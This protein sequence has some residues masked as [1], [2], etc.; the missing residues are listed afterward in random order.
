MDDTP[1]PTGTTSSAAGPSPGDVGSFA[2]GGAVK[3]KSCNS[4]TRKSKARGPRPGT[5]RQTYDTFVQG[6]YAPFVRVVHRMTKAVSLVPSS[7]LAVPAPEGGPAQEP[8]QPVQMMTVWR[9]DVPSIIGSTVPG[10]ASAEGSGP[11]PQQE[12]MLM[13]VESSDGAVRELNSILAE[14]LASEEKRVAE[15]DKSRK[16]WAD[17][18]QYTGPTPHVLSA[19]D[20]DE[21]VG[22]FIDVTSPTAVT[23]SKSRY[24]ALYNI[25]YLYSDDELPSANTGATAA[26]VDEAAAIGG[27]GGAGDG[28][29]LESSPGKVDGPVEKSA[30]VATAGTA[31]L[32]SGVAQI[33]SPATE[34]PVSFADAVTPVRSNSTKAELIDDGDARQQRGTKPAHLPSS[35]A[36]STEKVVGARVYVDG[37]K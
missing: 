37:E 5:L 15:G 28:V 20:S 16:E 30:E 35:R 34:I 25:R 4:S 14:Y 26:A 23:G 6:R 29:V 24:R 27:L 32:S 13:V 10:R 11:P 31:S 7:H 22:E 19:K 12:S 33:T 17:A 36:W 3:K 9:V 21:R 2:G 18:F 1:S 8:Y